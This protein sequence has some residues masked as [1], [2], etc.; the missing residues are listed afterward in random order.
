M[1]KKKTPRKIT[2]FLKMTDVRSRVSLSRAMIYRLIRQGKFPKA[3]T[4][5]DRRVGWAESEV[6][7]WMN[8][9]MVR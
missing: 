6:D 2:K 4:L 8:D 5:S 3:Y 1:M 9:R 7:Q